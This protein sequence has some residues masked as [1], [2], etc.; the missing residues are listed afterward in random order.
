MVDAHAAE[1]GGAASR[2]CVCVC[3]NCVSVIAVF[4]VHRSIV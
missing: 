1:V 4:Y 3:V 2:V